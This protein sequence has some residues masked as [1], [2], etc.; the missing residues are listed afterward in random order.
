LWVYKLNKNK[1]ERLN[2]V[3][4][5]GWERIIIIRKITADFLQEN[6]TKDKNKTL[7]GALYYN[8]NFF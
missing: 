3:V 5:R 4:E 2:K 6:L 7:L 8:G 1:W